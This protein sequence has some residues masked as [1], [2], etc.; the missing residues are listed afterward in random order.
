MVTLFN[1]SLVEVKLNFNES[2]G[3]YVLLATKF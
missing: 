2:K 3:K 1:Q